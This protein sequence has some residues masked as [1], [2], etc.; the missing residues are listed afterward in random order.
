[1]ADHE[2]G[3]RA[4]TA[5][6]FT[7]GDSRG[8]SSRRVGKRAHVATVAVGKGDLDG[9]WEVEEE[10]RGAATSG[11]GAVQ[12]V[13]DGGVDEIG[14]TVAVEVSHLD[15]PRNVWPEVGHL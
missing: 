12:L 2:V 3:C 9:G 6:E 4:G 5:L 11:V 1:M 15:D 13:S 7:N 10:T 8:P 14:F